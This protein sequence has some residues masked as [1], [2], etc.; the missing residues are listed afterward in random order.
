MFF[1]FEFTRQF[2]I[3][4]ENTVASETIRFPARTENGD[5]FT[6]LA[7]GGGCAD[8]AYGTTLFMRAYQTSLT[9]DT[10]IL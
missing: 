3:G 4:M 2:Y 6:V 8:D 9:F 7:G 10:L 5:G 1:E